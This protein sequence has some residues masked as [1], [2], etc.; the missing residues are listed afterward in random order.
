MAVVLSFPLI[1]MMKMNHLIIFR[2]AQIEEET[3]QNTHNRLSKTDFT[4]EMRWAVG[5]TNAV[6][7]NLLWTIHGTIQ[8]R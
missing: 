4:T 8:R 3:V 2:S 1:R 6:K 7:N 5:F